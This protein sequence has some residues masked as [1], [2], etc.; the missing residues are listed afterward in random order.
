MG[1]ACIFLCETVSMNPMPQPVSRMSDIELP[2]PV[3]VATTEAAVP[4]SPR[5]D[6]YHHAYRNLNLR[7]EILDL[8]IVNTRLMIDLMVEQC[9]FS[10]A[11][12]SRK[13]STL[14]LA[15]LSF[16]LGALTMKARLLWL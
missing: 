11:Q 5:P 3:Q 12:K 8:K 14:Q 16:A 13:F 10:L 6:V 9:R 4:R 1:L 15:V 7:L 2:R